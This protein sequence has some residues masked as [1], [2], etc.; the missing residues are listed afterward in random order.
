MHAFSGKDGHGPDLSN[1]LAYYLAG[2]SICFS[3]FSIS[4]DAYFAARQSDFAAAAPSRLGVTDPVFAIYL[5]SE[6]SHVFIA[7]PEMAAAS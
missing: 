2:T 6:P 7:L 1:K 5:G 3:S 4:S